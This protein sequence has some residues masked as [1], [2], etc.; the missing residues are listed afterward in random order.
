MRCGRNPENLTDRQAAKL[1]S[2][3]KT[4][5][6][7]YRAYLLLVITLSVSE[8]LGDFV[9]QAKLTSNLAHLMPKLIGRILGEPETSEVG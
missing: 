9:A 4:N 8:H 6:R 3:Q 2:I 7:L 5:A 1:S